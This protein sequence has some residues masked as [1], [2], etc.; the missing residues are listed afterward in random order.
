MNKKIHYII[1]SLS[2]FFS[3]QISVLSQAT[4][5]TTDQKNDLVRIESD[6]G[7]FS[8]ELPNNGA[9]FYDKDG[10]YLNNVM[11]NVYN[12]KE[13]QMLNASLD[14]TYMSVE[15]YRMPNPKNYLD[16]I[17]ERKNLAYSK[18]KSDLKDFLVYKAE[19]DRSYER[20]KKSTENVNF[21][22][23]Y[24]ASKTHFYIA[25]VWNKGKSTPVS[26]RFLSSIR[27]G[28]AKASN[29]KIIKISAMKPVTIEQIGGQLSKKEIE[30]LPDNPKIENGAPGE[31]FVLQVPQSGFNFAAANSGAKGIVR[32]YVTY[33][34]EGRIDK[35]S[36]VSGLPGGLNRLAFFS[37]LRTKF[38]PA[39][40]DGK[41]VTIERVINYDYTSQQ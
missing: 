15:V 19:F 28:S 32:L 34:K 12:F 6:N 37:I 1:L 9:Y 7:E 10:F 18:V 29:E 38:L 23:R 16:V 30:A 20:I 35:I 39:E 2:L 33:S 4:K 24:I 21:E 40:K 8:I 36:L 26:E 5:E 3:A 14:K 13:M 31:L 25:T 41:P 17:S 22:I 27:L 11:G